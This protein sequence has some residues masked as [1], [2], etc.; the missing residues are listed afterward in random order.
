MTEIPSRWTG[1]CING[2]NFDSS[3]CNKKLI[4]ARFYNKGLIA[5]G[6]NV[7]ISMNSTRDTDG[8]GTH[9]S[10]TAAG[11]YVEGASFF[12]YARGTASGMAPRAH[13]AMYKPL[14]EESGYSSDIIAAIDQAILDGVDVMSLS[15]GLDGLPLYE[16][17]VTIATFAAMEKALSQLMKISRDEQ[18]QLRVFLHQ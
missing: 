3:K 16:D 17:P 11:N 18:Q 2:T 14:W 15:F 13:V 10:S 5:N 12:S 8:H 7:T 9:T 1:Q 4:G 6:P